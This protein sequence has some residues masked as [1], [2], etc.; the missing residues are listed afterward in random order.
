MLASSRPG[1]SE[2]HRVS[3]GPVNG[4]GDCPHFLQARRPNSENGDCPHFLSEDHRVSYGPVNGNGDC[5]HF[6]RVRSC[7]A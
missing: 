6:P 2:D 3:H 5:P 1:L 7:V 4:N